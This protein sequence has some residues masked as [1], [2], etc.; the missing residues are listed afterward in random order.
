MRLKAA[1]W[2][3]WRQEA[4]LSLPDATLTAEPASD[5]E[6]AEG[7]AEGV[8]DV[9][10]PRPTE[11]EEEEGRADTDEEREEE[12]EEEKEEEEEEEAG[13]EAEEE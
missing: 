11:G 12:E 2:T 3:G 1:L 8:R 13:E 5:R 9:V 7:E 10:G 4:L 6:I